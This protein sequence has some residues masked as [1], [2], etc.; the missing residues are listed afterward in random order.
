MTDKFNNMFLSTQGCQNIN[1]VSSLIKMATK[2]IAMISVFAALCAVIS[3]LP[4]IPIYGGA[5]KIEFT[6][7]LFPIAGLIMGPGTGALA[8][9]I[10]N[11]VTWIIPTS[12]I[13]GLLLIPAG[14][15]SAL[16]A[17]SLGRKDSLT[18]WRMAAIVLALIIFSWY[19]TPVGLEAP[20]YPLP[21][22]AALVLILAFRNKIFDFV[23]SPSKKKAILG[24]ALCSYAGTMAEQLV[25]SLIFIGAVG[26]VVPLKAV[27]DAINSIG[28]LSVKLGLPTSIQTY[29]RG[30]SEL[31]GI[32]KESAPSTLGILF[33]LMI[34]IVLT[35]RLIITAVAT[36]IGAATLRIIQK[37][38]L[39]LPIMKK[40]ENTKN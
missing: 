12:T 29:I 10:G 28:L 21:H 4:G 2:Q 25:G 23:Q 13:M 24:T 40:K 31:L 38:R 22:V 18:N 30:V 34:P 15:F 6:T 1:L 7:V 27:R 8:V 35:E 14:A 32:P 9:L 3:R 5:G 11:F 36:S 37:G 20:L 39:G 17:G 26:L 33:M 19:L 16:I